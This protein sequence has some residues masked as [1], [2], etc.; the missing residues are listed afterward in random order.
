L[1]GK[2]LVLTLTFVLMVTA[3]AGTVSANIGQTKKEYVDY[4][5]EAVLTAP[6][7]SVEVNQPNIVIEGYRP[8][9]GVLSCEVTINDNTYS[10][11]DDF[12]Y[13]ENFRIEGNVI[14]GKGTLEVKTLF[15]FNLPGHPQLT[16][17]L[18]CQVA[19]IGTGNMVIEE[20]SF[21][22][23]GNKLLNQVEGGGTPASTQVA[24]VDNALHIGQIIGWPFGNQ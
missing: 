8:S 1:N 3:L 17:Y 22:L 24:G 13:T 16:E 5:F 14:T 4:R 6:V 18:Y 9:S 19:G 15:T 23:T 10:Y 20:G 2:F 21:S 7:V 12:Q 11:P